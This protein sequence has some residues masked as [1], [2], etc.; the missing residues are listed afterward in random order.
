MWAQRPIVE[1][2]SQYAFY[3]PCVEAVASIIGDFPS[4]VITSIL[5]NV[6]IYFLTNLRRSVS[7]FFTFWV[8]GFV[9]LVTMSMF[10]RMVG[11][12]SRTVAQTMAPVAIFLVNYIIY[13]GFVL[14]PEY[15]RPWLSWV[16]HIDPVAYAFESLMLNE[17]SSDSTF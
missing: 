3:H 2:Q 15:M 6:A 8:F 5:F 12:L 4:K 13:T 14:P 11:S 17:V 7:A 16:R 9:C 10:F 1:K